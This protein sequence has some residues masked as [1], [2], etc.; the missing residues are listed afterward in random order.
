MEKWKSASVISR[1]EIIEYWRNSSEWREERKRKNGELEARKE[2]KIQL[3]DLT[4]DKT[5]V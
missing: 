5:Q 1:E 3:S 2:R 4:G